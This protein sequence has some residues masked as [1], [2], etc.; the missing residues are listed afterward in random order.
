MQNLFQ[1]LHGQLWHAPNRVPPPWS[2]R[3]GA[4]GCIEV[5]LG[6]TSCAS[7]VQTC[8]VSVQ[9]NC[10]V[11][12][13]W[14]RR[15]GVGWGDHAY[16]FKFNNQKQCSKSAMH[17]SKTRSDHRPTCRRNGPHRSFSK[18]SVRNLRRYDII[19][20]IYHRRRYDPTCVWI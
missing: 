4:K 15:C 19:E 16:M 14:R 7:A 17:V 9:V 13:I 6:C 10:S 3:G 1:E 2:L 20:Y 5:T 18:T 11:S 12:L 8:K